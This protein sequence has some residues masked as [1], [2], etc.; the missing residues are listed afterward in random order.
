MKAEHYDHL[1]LSFLL[2]FWSGLQTDE[3]IKNCW[4]LPEIAENGQELP[5]LDHNFVLDGDIDEVTPV[6]LP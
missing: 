2:Y 1:V 6:K 3:E 5:L 4:K